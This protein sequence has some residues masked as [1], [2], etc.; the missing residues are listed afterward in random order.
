MDCSI[1]S[2]RCL[3]ST[4]IATLLLALPI[5]ATASESEFESAEIS[6][7]E[8]DE[9]VVDGRRPSRDSRK[10]VSWLARLVGEFHIDGELDLTSGPGTEPV[11]LQGRSSCIGFGA[12]PAVMCT[13]NIHSQQMREDDENGT[14]GAVT[15]LNPAIVMFG[16]EPT[17]VGI[18]QMLVGSDGVAD[19]AL[20]YLFPDD[21]LVG[22]AKCGGVVGNCER[23]VRIVA[24]PLAQRVHFEI[25]TFVNL[26]K[27]VTI[28]F[29]MHRSTGSVPPAN[30]RAVQ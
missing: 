18:H 5:D 9:V 22:R 21:S 8:L 19:S 11:Y 12:K 24:D 10:V 13:L 2:G 14:V 6:N 26:R 28:V 3:L 17:R 15:N 1:G 25:E 23:V 30:H 16:F 7:E 27:A 4:S 29:T 20:G